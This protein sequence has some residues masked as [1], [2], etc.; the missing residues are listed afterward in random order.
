MKNKTVKKIESVAKATAKKTAV[1]IN[2][3]DK[4]IL[5]AA[6]V[7]Q[8]EWKKSEPKR[9]EYKKEIKKA[10]NKAGVKGVALFKAGVK[11]S[12]KI[13]G[14]IAKVVKKDVNKIRKSK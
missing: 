6:K 10:A 13:G 9:E 1:L 11:N 4:E 5:K 2:K 14:D 7:I 8:K 3:A 12:I